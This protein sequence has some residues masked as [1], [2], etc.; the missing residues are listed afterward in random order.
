M[1]TLEN[2]YDNE[3]VDFMNENSSEIVG[4][5]G[6]EIRETTRGRPT[7]VLKKL[8]GDGAFVWNTLCERIEREGLMHPPKKY[9]RNVSNRTQLISDK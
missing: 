2:T 3:S 8:K 1:F 6:D 4:V 7:N 9:S 5:F